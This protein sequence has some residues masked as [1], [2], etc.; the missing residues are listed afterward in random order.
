[1]DGQDQIGG[2]LAIMGL[3]HEE[4]HRR[5]QTASIENGRRI[6]VTHADGCERRLV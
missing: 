5:R 4:G 6:S 2:G 3:G 1:V